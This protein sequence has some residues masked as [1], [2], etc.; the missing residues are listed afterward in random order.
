[1]ILRTS[2]THIYNIGQRTVKSMQEDG[3][4][5]GFVFIPK[6]LKYVYVSS[7]VYGK[8]RLIS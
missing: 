4:N 1:M 3:Y 5:G 7:S 8:Q 6:F 2:K